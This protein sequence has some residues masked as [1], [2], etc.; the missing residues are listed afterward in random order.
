M[1]MID[2][3]HDLESALGFGELWLCRVEN[4]WLFRWT[5][6]GY[7]TDYRIELAQMDLLLED[8]DMAKMLAQSL[9]AK[10]RGQ[11][12]EATEMIGVVPR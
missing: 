3:Y 8:T 4:N 5:V 9:G 1:M 11:Y 2:F 10:M 6:D 7:Y 12:Q